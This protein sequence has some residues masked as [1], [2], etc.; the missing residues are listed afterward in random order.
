[1]V[2]AGRRGAFSYSYFEEQIENQELVYNAEQDKSKTEKN[3]KLSTKIY[4]KK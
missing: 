1:M 2:I 3:K 4:I